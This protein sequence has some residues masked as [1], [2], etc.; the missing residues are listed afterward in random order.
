MFE[1]LESRRMFSNVGV[2]TVPMG[3]SL[4]DGVVRV[5][6][7]A[8]HDNAVVSFSF[9][10]QKLTVTLDRWEI[11][12]TEYGPLPVTHPTVTKQFDPAQV[13]SIVF[14]GLDGN[15][16][17]TNGTWI[18]STAF[19]GT[20]NDV[21]KGGSGNDSLRGGDGHD[22]L[23]G[24]AGNDSL[25]GDA[26]SDLLVGG[27]GSDHL[28]AEDGIA[29]NDDVFGDNQDGSGGENAFDIAYIDSGVVYGIIPVW[30]SVTGCEQVEDD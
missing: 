7:A 17:F 4:A 10:T 9:L 24:R 5:K 19:G 13:Q 14:Y 21:L 29:G 26:G 15:D 1:S 25:W 8:T 16:G 3:I 12:G 2:P 18:K 20:G 23:F 6:G 27:A 11:I 28:Y 30:D 22:D